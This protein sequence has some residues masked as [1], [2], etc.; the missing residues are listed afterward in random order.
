MASVIKPRRGNSAPTTGL[1]QNEIAVDTTNKRIYVGNASGAGELIGSSPGGSNSH[2]QFNDS[3]NFGGD[4]GLTYNKTTDVL[5]VSGAV[6]SDGGFRV[7]SGAI[8]SQ[9]DSY[10]LSSSDN[11]KVITVNASSVKTITIPTGLSVGFNC[12]VIRIGTGRVNFSADVG[13]VLNSVDSLVEISSQHGAVSLI[14]YSS[15]V[16]NLSGNLT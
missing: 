5:T 11:G 1:I 6:V 13:V 14:S 7:T 2:V 8:V 12:T 10:T 4:S 16:F 9:T 3:G 15:N